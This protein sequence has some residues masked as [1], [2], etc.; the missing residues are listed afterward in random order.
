M[1]RT[2]DPTALKRLKGNPG[3]RPI[4]DSAEPAPDI[5][6]LGP[7]PEELGPDARRHWLEL[8]PQLVAMRTLGDVDR[9]AFADLCNIRADILWHGREIERLRGL[10]RSLTGKQRNDLQIAAGARKKAIE[11]YA[12]LSK[13]YGIGAAS[14]TK[15]KVAND[16]GQIELPLGTGSGLGLAPGSTVGDVHLQELAGGLSA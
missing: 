5:S 11:T 3:H 7:P 15:I 1:G 16:N 13:E 14:R 8:G 4:D 12:K 9:A 6:D 2:P 10:K